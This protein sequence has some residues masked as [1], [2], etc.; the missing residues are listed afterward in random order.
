M[1]LSNFL[2]Q[3]TK[4]KNIFRG[5]YVLLK[6]NTTGYPYN[7]S[8]EP[9][10]LPQTVNYYK[11]TL[12]LLGYSID[13]GTEVYL[14]STTLCTIL[15]QNVSGYSNNILVRRELARSNAEQPTISW[16]LTEYY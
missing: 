2:R 8:E 5:E 13:L 1:E 12:R 14:P 15:L 10:P 11:S 7:A 4:I 16:E 3:G 9:I 6:G